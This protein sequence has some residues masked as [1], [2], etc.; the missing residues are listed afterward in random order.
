[1]SFSSQHEA[2]WET[3]QDCT[4]KVT[5]LQNLQLGCCKQK[6]WGKRGNTEHA[7]LGLQGSILYLPQ[8]VLQT[9]LAKILRQTLNQLLGSCR[10]AD[11]CKA[12]AL[13]PQAPGDRPVSQPEAAAPVTLPTRME[14]GSCCL[15]SKTAET[16]G[17]DLAITGKLWVE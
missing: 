8:T 6:G 2:A 13:I 15:V 1:M 16:G 10:V 14:T 4:I 17:L 11:L 7:G 5:C 3:N 9:Y 12:S